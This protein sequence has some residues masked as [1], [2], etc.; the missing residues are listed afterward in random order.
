MQPGT[1]IGGYRVA[2]SLGA[3]GMGE[4]WRA[5]DAKLGRDEHAHLVFTRA[6]ECE[7]R[8]GRRNLASARCQLVAPALRDPLAEQGPVHPDGRCPGPKSFALTRV[9]QILDLLQRALEDERG[10][11][12]WAKAGVVSPAKNIC[13]RCRP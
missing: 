8:K 12:D 4:V 1:T 10:I 5:E 9:L 7:C 13:R 6:P 11:I 3:G 2:S